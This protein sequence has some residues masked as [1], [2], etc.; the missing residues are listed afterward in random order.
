MMPC[1]CECRV[2]GSL[3]EHATAGMFYSNNS[4]FYCVW[5]VVVLFVMNGNLLAVQEY[6]VS[7]VL[8]FLM[9]LHVQMKMLLKDA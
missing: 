1:C 6:L 5:C 2:L 4:F 9:N 7:V 3:D 8:S